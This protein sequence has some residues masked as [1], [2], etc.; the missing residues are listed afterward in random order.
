MSSGYRYE[1][2]PE[3]W[4]HAV[5]CQVYPQSYQDTDGDGMGDLP[6][7]LSRLGHLSWLGVGAVWLSPVYPSPM[8]DGGYDVSDYTGIDPRFGTMEDFDRLLSAMREAGI[9]LILDC[10][11]NHS[12]DRH[13]WFAESRASRGNPRRDWY[14]WADPAR[15]G[16]PPNNWLSR[17]GGSAWKLDEGTGQYYYH[18]FHEAQPDLNWRNP[19]VR[20]AMA[21]VLRFW[22]R[23][24]ADGFRLDATGVLIEDALLRDDPPK[25]DAGDSTPPPERQKRV[26][27]DSRPEAIDCIV[28]LR[29]ALDEFPERLLMGEADVST[30]RATRFYGGRDRPALHFPLNFRLLDTPWD[31]RSLAAAIDEYLNIVPPHGWPCWALGGHDKRR[32]AGCVGPAQA[33]VAAML[34][35]T[36]PGTAIFYAGDEI[37]MPNVEIP[38]DRG[39]DPFEKLVPGY[40]LSRDPER[41]PMR[42]DSGPKAGFT[43]GEPWLPIGP[44]VETVNVATQRDDPRSI[45]A[46]YRALIALRRERTA[47][48]GNGCEPLRSEGDVLAF[49]RRA[50]G[51]GVL[52][53]LNLGAEAASFSLGDRGRVLLSTH[54]DR[55]GEACSGALQLRP[56]EGLVLALG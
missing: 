2:G 31:A 17:F 32:I 9:R 51:Q 44:D 14:V 4:R 12:S 10:V 35:M 36:L 42:W 18:A 56:D 53:A 16:G 6:G 25:P 47:L 8:V 43:T 54:L 27:T 37:G 38:A 48:R 20:E 30:D 28:G 41:T 39:Q 34:H 45:L 7:I 3:W 15:D 40:D 46:L 22:L 26:F 5:I 13:P 21:E 50:G 11:P 29:E 33:R 52:V 19:A 55:A 23:R 24:G 49:R 1:G